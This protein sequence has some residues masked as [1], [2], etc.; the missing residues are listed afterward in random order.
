MGKIIAGRGG[1]AEKRG[2]FGLAGEGARA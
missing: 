1:K 2:L